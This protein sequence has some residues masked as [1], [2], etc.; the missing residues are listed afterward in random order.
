MMEEKLLIDLI[1][2]DMCSK[3]GRYDG[4]RYYYF[5]PENIQT[6]VDTAD[7]NGRIVTMDLKN[8]MELY[9]NWFKVLV[10]QKIDYLLAKEPTVNNPTFDVSD[11]LDSMLLNSSLD[12]TSW[13]YFFINKKGKLDISIIYDVEILPIYDHNNKDL[14]TLIRYY[15][16][17]E[18][19]IKAEVW[20]LEGVSIV[21]IEK[22]KIVSIE[23]ESHYSKVM[24]YQDQVENILNINFLTIPFIPLYNNRDKESDIEGIKTL[25][26]MYN[27][28]SSGFVQNINLFQEA[29]VKL[30]GFDANQEEFLKNLKKHKYVALPSDGEMEYLKIEIPVEARK[31]VLEMIKQNIFV[32]GRGMN[33]DQ[34][35]DGNITNII[36]KS[37]YAQLDMK[38]SLTEKQIKTFYKKFTSFINEYQNS[39]LDDS[40]EMNKTMLFNESEKIADCVESIKLVDAGVLSKESLM[41]QIPYIFNVEEEKKLIALEPK[42]KE[43]SIEDPTN[44][45]ATDVE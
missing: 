2:K 39:N 20:T 42:I 45:L 32:L 43:D 36:I 14:V 35:G 34:V 11:M 9:T 1:K 38:A 23:N 3:Q 27:S 29:I 40:I 26:D 31:V 37:R 12:S 8:S 7:N 44:S 5:K 13:V 41:K 25:L 18:K 10:N 6:T 16:F 28:I 15:K 33:P 30:K 21:I 22:D 4:R 19:Q 24:V 17:N